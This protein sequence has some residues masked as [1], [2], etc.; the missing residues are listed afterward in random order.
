[1]EV[2]QECPFCNLPIDDS[3]PTVAL[4]GKGSDTINRISKERDL[5]IHVVPGQIVHTDCR[6][7]FIHPRNQ[8]D[9]NNNIN[10]NYVTRSIVT[11]DFRNA[12]IFC[13]KHAKFNSKKRGAD[14]FPVR[15]IEFQDTI[16]QKC[17]ERNDSWSQEVF[18]R[19]SSVLD[20]PAADALYHQ[21]VN[22]RT[23]RQIPRSYLDICETPQKKSPGR[24]DYIDINERFKTVV[25]YVEEHE[26][27]ILNLSD[28]VKV[29]EDS[30]G[31]RAYTKKHFKSKLLDHFGENISISTLEGKED[32]VCLR[33]K[34][35]TIAAYILHKI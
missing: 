2:K 11:F 8:C 6:R 4:R 15:T 14:V 20:L 7:D 12:C 3:K 24:P 32:K 23:L 21:N 31:E 9:N 29:M 10:N 1:M 34:L 25:S 19:I 33:R 16:K 18:N 13:G 27:T 28:L 35:S 26:G 17:V 22:F 5:S 30:C